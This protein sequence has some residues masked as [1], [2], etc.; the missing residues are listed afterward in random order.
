MSSDKK[1]VIIGA[2]GHGRVCADIAKLCGYEVS[3]LDDNAEGFSGGHQIIGKTEDYKNYISGYSFFVAVGNGEIRKK[4]SEEIEKN[5]AE[6]VSL[7]H[8]FSA[9]S[10]D[11]K[12][13]KGSVVMAGAVIN[14]GTVINRGA[15]IN[16]CSSVDHDCEIGEYS[17]VAVGVHV[18][19]TVSVGKN[20]WLGAGS[21]VINNINICDDCFIGAGA[22]VVK[23][24]DVSGKY[25]GVPA[26][27]KN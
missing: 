23:N 1:L 26:K 15:I 17:H 24:I 16:T 27:I 10:E 3:F 8:P 20:V 5:G 18:C 11:V 9:V 7:M 14:P 6:I 19:G 4:I 12:I 22:V 13:E 25:I 21:T 2:G